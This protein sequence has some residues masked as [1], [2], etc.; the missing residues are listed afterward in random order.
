MSIEALKAAL[1]A[2]PT[3]GPWFVHETLGHA[4]C[5]VGRTRVAKDVPPQGNKIAV[6]AA[7]FAACDPEIIRSLLKDAERL[8]WLLGQADEAANGW[9]I[10]VRVGGAPSLE[11][12]RD[13]IDAAMGEQA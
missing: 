10:V 3:E 9:A 6:D 12:L 2:G 7:Y 5:S 4:V 13:A 8:Q 1:A 11:T